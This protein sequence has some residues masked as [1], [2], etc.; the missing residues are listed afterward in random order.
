MSAEGAIVRRLSPNPMILARG[1]QRSDVP[2]A[3]LPLEAGDR[4]SRSSARM[5]QLLR[6]LAER[7]ASCI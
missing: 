2:Q 7:I 4:R 3:D 1:S 5:P 6:R